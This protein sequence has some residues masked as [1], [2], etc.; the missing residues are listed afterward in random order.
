V[1]G[2]TAMLNKSV[3][4]GLL[5]RNTALSLNYSVQTQ[6]HQHSASTPASE[7]N[8]S[9]QQQG[10]QHF[11]KMMVHHDQKTIKMVDLA[12]QKAKN[13][14]IKV[15]ATQIKT[16]KPNKLSNCKLCTNSCMAQKLLLM[17]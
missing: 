12:L 15:L 16:T 3:N 11:L 6:Q 4:S 1:K 14:Q 7:T 17:P 9:P 10:D 13:P 2:S 5:E 8:T